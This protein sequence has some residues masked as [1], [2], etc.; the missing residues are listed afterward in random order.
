MIRGTT[1][2]GLISD[3]SVVSAA[4]AYNEVLKKISKNPRLYVRGPTLTLAGGGNGFATNGSLLL[5]HIAV[6][7][8]FSA[9]NAITVNCTSCDVVV[10]EGR[11]ENLTQRLDFGTWFK[12][13]FRD[14]HI[15]YMGGKVVMFESE[16]DNCTFEFAPSVSLELRQMIASGTIVVPIPSSLQ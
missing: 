12:C 10:L 11:F 4:L 16:F 1:K 6:I 13:R 5:D 9:S 7:A 14:C 15:S 3:H 2:T 8:K